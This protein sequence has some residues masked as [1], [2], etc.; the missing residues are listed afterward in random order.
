M[1][2]STAPADRDRESPW[3][4]SLWSLLVF[5]ARERFRRRH[6]Y[7]S[8]AQSAALVS[9]AAHNYICS[10]LGLTG[11]QSSWVGINHLRRTRGTKGPMLVI[12]GED[13]LYPQYDLPGK[14]A[15]AMQEW[16][17]WAAEQAR[18]MLAAPERGAPHVR[19][20]WERLAG[21][22]VTS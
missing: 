20:H 15:E 8:S 4:R 18:E 16:Q 9:V 14:L 13:M 21:E 10:A 6:T 2:D 12:D 22:E 3:P 17:P 11:F 19:E 5:I 7:D 1:P